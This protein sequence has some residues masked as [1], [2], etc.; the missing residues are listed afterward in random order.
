MNASL[1]DEISAV[2]CASLLVRLVHIP[3]DGA[4]SHGPPIAEQGQ[5]IPIPDYADGTTV[6]S[7]NV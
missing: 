3:R 6:F 1:L 4:Y 5:G 2:P 7:E